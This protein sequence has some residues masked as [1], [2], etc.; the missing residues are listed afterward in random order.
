MSFD[1]AELT[2]RTAS[3]TKLDRISQTVHART[4]LCP[5]GPARAADAL[6]RARFA[7]PRMQ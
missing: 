3:A 4:R 1:C 6:L 7:A 2:V 5:R